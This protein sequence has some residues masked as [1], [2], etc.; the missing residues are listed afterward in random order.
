MANSATRGP[1]HH[2]SF[3]FRQREPRVRRAQGP[4]VVAAVAH[5]A[6]DCLGVRVPYGVYVQAKPVMVIRYYKI[7]YIQYVRYLKI[8]YKML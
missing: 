8:S 2:G 5:H 1:P 4:A 6:G 7:L 3:G